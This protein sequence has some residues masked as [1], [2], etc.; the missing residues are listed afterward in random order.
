[1][2]EPT[3]TPPVPPP[4]AASPPATPAPDMVTVTI[5]GR[6]HQFPKGT[7]LLEACNQV[8]CN[9]P[10]LLL[11]RGPLLAGRVPPV[12]GRREGAAE[13]GPL[14]LHA[15]RRQDGGHDELAEGAGHPAPDA[16]VHAAQPS[17]RLPDLRQGG[18]V[19]AAEALLRLGRDSRVDGIKVH[20]DK[21][22]DLGPH[23]CSTRSAAS[24]APAA[25]ASATRSRG[26]APAHDV[27]NRG[28]HEVLTTAPGQQLDNPYSLNTVDVCPVGALTSKDFRFEMRAWELSRRRRC[29][30]AARPA[31]TSRST[32]R[33]GA[34]SASCPAHNP[35]VNKFWMCDEGRF[36]YKPVLGG[37]LAVPLSTAPRSRGTGPSTRRR[38]G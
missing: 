23:S 32:T 8:G 37:R 11:P 33:T 34:S 4:P 36:T 10:V 18:R 27:A 2:P 16:R 35:A 6:A 26:V 20:K 15:S 24:C 30:P 12:S 28:D 5:D 29:A 31:A 21:V 19:H 1:M 13:A 25:S 14:L 3:Q 7:N 22:V 17:H 9:V 38:R